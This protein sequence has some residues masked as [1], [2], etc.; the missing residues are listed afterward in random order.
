MATG[1]IFRLR[2]LLVKSRHFSRILWLLLC[3]PF[4]VQAADVQVVGLSKGQAVIV[5]NGGKPRLVRE[6]ETTP[7]GVKL[8]AAD[9]A[10]AVIEANG[11]RRTLGLGQAVTG[12]GPAGDQASVT[13]IS[14]SRGHFIASGQINGAPVQFV[15]DTGATLVTLPSR[16]AR[17]IGLYYQGGAQRYASTANGLVSIYLVKL[18]EV[19]V[20]GVLLRNVDAAVQE[21]DSLPVI[22]LGMSFLNRV[23]M[24]QEGNTLTLKKRF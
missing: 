6:G 17:R 13:L 5:V 8:L 24:R 12:G 20:G 11:V 1:F 4:A 19:R 16:E 23:E 22:L 14:D 7:E 2:L 10:Q 15:V 18:D 21:G 3:A 9:S